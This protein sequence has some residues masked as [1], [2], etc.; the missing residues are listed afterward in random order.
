MWLT[1]LL[2]EQWYCLDV[3]QLREILPQRDVVPVAGSHPHVKGIINVRGQI[4][5]V[6]DLPLILEN[7]E[8]RSAERL[9]VA[10]LNDEVLIAFEVSQVGTMLEVPHEQLDTSS[11]SETL[12]GTLL[13]DGVIY[14]VVDIAQ[15]VATLSLSPCTSG[16]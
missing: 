6:L 11:H 7:N 5:P 8:H 15:V 2:D 13:V 9:V 1:F 14:P 10:E 16:V 12:R 3:L 4:V